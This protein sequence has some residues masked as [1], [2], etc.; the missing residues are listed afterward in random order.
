M[1]PLRL[2]LLLLLICH[3]QSVAVAA[4]APQTLRYTISSNG[5]VAGNEIDTYLPDGRVESSFEFNDRG[6]GPKVSAH[7]V[8]DPS[9]LPLRV[10][11]TGNDYLKAPVDE[12]FEVKDGIAHWKST[13]EDGHAPAGAFYV[14]NNG[15]AAELAFLVASLQKAHGAPVH[16][17]PAGEARLERLT[18]FTLEDHGQRMHVTD[19][20]ITGLS[21]EPQTLWLDDEQHFFASPGT[22]FAMLREGWEKT[23]DQLYAIDVKCA[24]NATRAWRKSWPSIRR[25]PWRLNMCACLIRNGP[26]CAK[27]RQLS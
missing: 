27:I 16:L 15:A 11:E 18:D 17:F 25:T 14:S 24:T 2:V 8:L 6:R 21:F 23:N 7:Y 3:W 1:F 9:G 20:A 26:Q 5:T 12:H 10:D 19:F 4:A 22:W 13:A